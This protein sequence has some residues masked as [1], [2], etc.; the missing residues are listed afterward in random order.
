MP[1]SQMLSEGEHQPK[2]KTTTAKGKDLRD[3]MPAY[4]RRR[5]EQLLLNGAEGLC[6]FMTANIKPSVDGT[7]KRTTILRCL[8]CFSRKQLSPVAFD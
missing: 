7:V 3:F 4:V 2:R 8:R 6:V 1:W 5:R